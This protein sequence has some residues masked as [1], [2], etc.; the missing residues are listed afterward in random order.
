M[1]AYAKA[2]VAII[3]AAVTAA[4]GIFPANST[5]WVILTIVSAALTAAG[6]Y[7]VPNKPAP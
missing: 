2:V 7:A 1:N 6:V 3:G 4:L 5:V